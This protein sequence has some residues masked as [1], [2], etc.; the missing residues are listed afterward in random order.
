MMT[1]MGSVLMVRGVVRA[2]GVVS[3]RVV[4]AGLVAV[5][6][7]AMVPRTRRARGPPRAWGAPRAPFRVVGPVARPPGSGCS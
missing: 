1:M 7:M 2:V 3:M 6:M 5:R 4:P